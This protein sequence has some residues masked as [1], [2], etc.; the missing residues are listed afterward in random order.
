MSIYTDD[1]VITG[2][3]REIL[4][5]KV[6]PAVEIFLKER[7]L[8]FSQNKT[9]ITHINEGFDFLGMNIGNRGEN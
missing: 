7:G 4:E 1:F 6:K 9:K 2:T 5:R 3:S 8:S